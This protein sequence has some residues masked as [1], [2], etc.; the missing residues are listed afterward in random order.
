[1][2]STG[3]WASWHA[4]LLIISPKLEAAAK[5]ASDTRQEDHVRRYPQSATIYRFE[6]EKEG[7]QFL[8]CRNEE[9]SGTGRRFSLEGDHILVE[10]TRGK[11]ILKI[12]LTLNEAGDCRYQ[13][14]GKEDLLR[15]Q[16]IRKTLKSILFPIANR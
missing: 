15:W 16:V 11:A 3:L 13:I 4:R 9:F 5:I 8:V 2:I 6:I 10:D 14:N 7:K 12:T 1:M